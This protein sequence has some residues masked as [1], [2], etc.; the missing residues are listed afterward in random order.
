MSLDEIARELEEIVGSTSSSAER[1]ARAD[2][3][4]RKASRFSNTAAD[5]YDTA[6]D[7][8]VKLSADEILAR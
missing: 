2:A 7:L 6:L 1:L 5:V 3:L 4:L 8:F